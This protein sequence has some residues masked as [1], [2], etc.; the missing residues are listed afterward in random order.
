[1]STAI[2]KRKSLHPWI[3]DTVEYYPHQIEGVRHLAG[4][5]NFLLADDMGLGKSLQAM[6][7]FA[8]D[9]YRGWAEKL[10]VICPVTLKGNW[11]DEFDKF[12]SFPHTVLQGGPAQREKQL[13]EFA[14]TPGPRV[15]IV[16]YEQVKPHLPMLNEINFDM[17]IIDE[18][19][20]IKN[21]KAARTKA[22]IAL[23]TRRSGI[24]TGTPMLNQ[25]NE[26]WP[27]LHIID[28]NAYPNYWAFVRRYC[29]FGGYKDKQIIGT[30]N[31]AEL[32]DRLN[33]VMLRRLKSEVLDLP[34][35]QIIE[36]RV[37]LH[38]EQRKVYETIRDDMKLPSS[39]TAMS[40]LDV[41]NSLTKFLRLKQVCG[42]LFSF[43]EEDISA[44]LD[45]VIEDDLEI[46][47][48]GHKIVQFTQFLD[49]Q[50][51]YV[52]RMR[53]E[54]HPVWI[55]NGAVKQQDRVPI[56]NQWAAHSQPGVIIGMLQIV[57][58]G[59]NGLV[60]SRHGSFIDELFVPG[61]NQQAIDRLNRIGQDTTQ[62]VQIRKYICRN[63][64]ENRVQQ[65]LR[66]KSKLFADIVETDPN[67]KRKLIE[68]VMEDEAA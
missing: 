5:K 36:R 20:Y 67:W 51:C 45:L 41:E 37:D 59:L 13:I 18:G 15:L 8:I 12:T 4:W 30:K 39:A 21:W 28:E 16:N 26:L 19:H 49:V 38:P 46:L 47:S 58:E 68:A 66:T 9:V 54:G 63:T 43:T 32:I 44:K 35:V 27:I 17:K 55:L 50:E 10:I 23:R 3:F 61:L 25:V 57:R 65:I 53:A 31:K 52:K 40:S 48:N 34:D 62:P 6:T 22:A 29:L 7:I 14:T 64:I 33:R 24:L 60:A 56:I 1:M 11:E 42:T 2:G